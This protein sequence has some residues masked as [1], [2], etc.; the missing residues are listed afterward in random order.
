[1]KEQEEADKIMQELERA[2]QIGENQL[3]LN[4]IEAQKGQ[5][6]NSVAFNE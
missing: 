6:A 5:Q 3:M 2:K 4:K 1:M